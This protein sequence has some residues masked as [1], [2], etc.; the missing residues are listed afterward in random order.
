MKKVVVFIAF[1]L[2]CSPLLA[3]MSGHN[4]FV[5]ENIIKTI[6]KPYSLDES[7][8]LVIWTN[9]TS[10]NYVITAIYSWSDTDDVAFTLKEITDPHD[11]SALTTIEAITISTNGT[12]VFY[13]ELTSGIDHTVIE[14]GHKIC[15]DNDATDNPDSIDIAIEGYYQL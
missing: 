13:N 4:D 7:E 6:A 10:Y 15:F 5:D 2:L 8:T 12:D 14:P 3:D 9:R 1:I 11:Y